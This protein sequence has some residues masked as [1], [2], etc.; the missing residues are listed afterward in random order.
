MTYCIPIHLGALLFAVSL[1]TITALPLPGGLS[2]IQVE[3]QVSSR[4]KGMWSRNKG[5]GEVGRGVANGSEVCR[6]K[7]VD[8]RGLALPS[9]SSSFSCVVSTS[10]TFLLFV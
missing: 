7:S 5:G 3:T 8:N 4:E 6:L 9:P 10:S 1:E 2:R